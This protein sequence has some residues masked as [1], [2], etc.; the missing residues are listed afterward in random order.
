MVEAI[1]IIGLLALSACAALQ[2]QQLR[3]LLALHGSLQQNMRDLLALQRQQ[4]AELEA[5]AQRVAAAEERVLMVEVL[6]RW[7]QEVVDPAMA[8]QVALEALLVQAA[9]GQEELSRVLEVQQDQLDLILP[10]RT[11]TK[12]APN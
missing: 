10:P 7:A 9:K 5:Q 11:K 2:R 12:S 4:R 8:R 3:D 6:E 1:L